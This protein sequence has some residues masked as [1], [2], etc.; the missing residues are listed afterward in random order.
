MKIGCSGW[1]IRVVRPLLFKAALIS[2]L[3]SGCAAGSTLAA[4]QILKTG[5]DL[6]SMWFFSLIFAMNLAAQIGIYNSGRLRCWWAWE[7]R[8]TSSRGSLK[9]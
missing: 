4:M 2:L 9:N 5:Q 1:N 6:Y 3:S 8:S 7:P